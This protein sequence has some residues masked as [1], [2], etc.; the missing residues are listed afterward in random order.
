MSFKKDDHISES[1][2]YDE[3][4]TRFYRGDKYKALQMDIQKL[5]EQLNLYKEAVSESLAI[6][7]H[8]DPCTYSNLQAIE[9]IKTELL[10]ITKECEEL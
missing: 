9:M 4:G 8:V 3:H 6:C 5:K 2:I 7:A 10:K 1:I